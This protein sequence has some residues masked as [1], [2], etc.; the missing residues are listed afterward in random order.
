MS[1]NFKLNKHRTIPLSQIVWNNEWRVQSYYTFSEGPC[2]KLEKILINR[3]RFYLQISVINK[4][5]RRSAI[6]RIHSTNFWRVYQTAPWVALAVT[7]WYVKHGAG[8]VT[9]LNMGPLKNAAP[10]C[11]LQSMLPQHFSRITAILVCPWEWSSLPS[12]S[13]VLL[14]F[15]R[16]LPGIEGHQKTKFSSEE[17]KKLLNVWILCIKTWAKNIWSVA[18]SC[19]TQRRVVI[20][21]IEKWKKLVSSETFALVYQTARRHIL[22]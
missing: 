1:S 5:R 18:I 13:D 8:S 20:F 2:C 6:W 11:G 10:A 15:R 22:E 3:R 19:G 4:F 17:N 9:V 14:R 7:Y 12:I 21:K 16:F